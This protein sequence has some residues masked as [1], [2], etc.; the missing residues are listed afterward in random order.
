M[1]TLLTYLLSERREVGGQLVHDVVWFSEQ[2]VLYEVSD[3]CLQLGV[4]THPRGVAF[5]QLLLPAFTR[6]R[7]TGSTVEG[8][9]ESA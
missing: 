5:L 1:Y 8:A 2:H 4:L 7:K 6:A 3:K 9:R